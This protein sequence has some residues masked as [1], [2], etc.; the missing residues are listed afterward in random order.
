MTGI[1]SAIV[2]GSSIYSIVDL[3]YGNNKMFI[4]DAAENARYI[5]KDVGFLEE[6]MTIYMAT[7]NEA[8][9]VLTFN[10]E[11]MRYLYHKP[12]NV[13]TLQK[14]TLSSLVVGNF[15]ARAKLLT[16]LTGCSQDNRRFMYRIGK[17]VH[18]SA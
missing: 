14:L 5:K 16:F 4:I 3:L 12:Y 17:S 1:G 11:M 10:Q 15:F 7:T 9:P 18:S 2:G 13:S 8:L 6:L